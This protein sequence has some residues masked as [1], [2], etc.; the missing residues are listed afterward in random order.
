MPAS[1][2]PEPETAPA[3]PAAERRREGRP[4]PESELHSLGAA[5]ERLLEAY[6][7]LRARAERAES[8]ERS[9]A[10]ALEGADLE[11]MAAEEIAVR[12]QEIA[13]ENRSLRQV[14]EESRERAQRIRSRLILME[15]EA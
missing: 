8:T 15:D 7:E 9:L 10:D 5:V 3:P 14:I 11:G 12:L 2:R 6:V 1:D 4:D 13:D